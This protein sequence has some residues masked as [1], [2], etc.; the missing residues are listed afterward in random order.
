MNQATFTGLEKKALKAIIA[1]SASNGH[2]FGVLNYVEWSGSRKQ[3]G[4][5]FTSLNAKGVVISVDET[6]VGGEKLTQY[7]LSPEY[8]GV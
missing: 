2:D 1:E 4:G 3:L 6:T 7:T 5:I 8:T